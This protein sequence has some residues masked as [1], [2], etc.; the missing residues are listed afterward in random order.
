[1]SSSGTG[2][3]ISRQDAADML[4][5][6]ITESTKVQALMHAKSGLTSGTIGVVTPK[7]DGTFWVI[8]DRITVPLTTFLAFRVDSAVRFK[9]GDRR[10]FAGPMLTQ[11]DGAPRLASALS[12]G[13]ADDSPLFE[14]D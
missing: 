5:K 6:F 9:Y 7:P 8:P 4:H 13:F 12:L 14:I 3:D 11:P 1:M 2:S 10:A